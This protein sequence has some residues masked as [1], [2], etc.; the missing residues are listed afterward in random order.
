MKWLRIFGTSSNL[1]G[2]SKW[3]NLDHVTNALVGYRTKDGK[4]IDY[5]IEFKSIICDYERTE[6][7]D[8]V[9]AT[10]EEAVK[11]FEELIDLA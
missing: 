1:Y 3:V 4:I 5:Y 6:Q 11:T 8:R 9:F 10:E 7:W 2:H